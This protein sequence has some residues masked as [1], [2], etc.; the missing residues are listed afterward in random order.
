MNEI[1]ATEYSNT[2]VKAELQYEKWKRIT[3]NRISIFHINK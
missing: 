2:S 1:S 3:L